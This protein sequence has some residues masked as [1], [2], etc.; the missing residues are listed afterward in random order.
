MRSAVAFE[1]SAYIKMLIKKKQELELEQR[2]QVWRN[3]AI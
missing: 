3:F 2:D 1:K